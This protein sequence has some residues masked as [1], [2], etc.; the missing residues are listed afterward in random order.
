MYARFPTSGRMTGLS[1]PPREVFRRRGLA[2]PVRCV[3]FFLIPHAWV[4]IFLIW[5]FVAGC[6]LDMF[7]QERTATVTSRQYVHSKKGSDRCEVRY[8]FNDQGGRHTGRG[9]LAGSGYRLYPAG[10]NISIRSVRILGISQS[11]LASRS[12]KGSVV[13]LALP[14]LFWNGFMFLFFYTTCLSPL[15][16]RR[17]LRDGEAVVGQITD[18]IVRKGKSTTYQISYMYP[19]PEGAPRNGRMNV[20]RQDYDLANAG[21]ESIVFYDPRWPT[22]SVLYAYS[23][24]ALRELRD[25]D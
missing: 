7:G 3:L 6:A 25:T 1:L 21:D 15:S 22:R 8:T 5:M 11:Q 16:E 19:G 17:L 4:G 20:R 12:G 24:Y 23:Q 2:V 14:M 13:C 18:K 10:A 9:S